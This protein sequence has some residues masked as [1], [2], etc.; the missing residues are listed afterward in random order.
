MIYIAIEITW[1]YHVVDAFIWA[2]NN[3]TD[4]INAVEWRCFKW[5]VEKRE[6]WKLIQTYWVGK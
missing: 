2:Y 4:A 5:K 1:D 3:I 6:D